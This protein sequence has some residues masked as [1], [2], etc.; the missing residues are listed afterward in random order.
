MDQD[1]A[2]GPTVGST[3]IE[4]RE[5]YDFETIG[6]WTGFWPTAADGARYVDKFVRNLEIDP[7]GLSAED[8]LLIS[9]F[10]AVN[11]D[12]ARWY[13]KR[14]GLERRIHVTF[15]IIS[16][17]LLVAL[18]VLLLK[19]PSWLISD[20]GSLKADDLPVITAQITAALTGFIAIHKA[21]G[22]WLGQRKVIGRFW[23]ARLKLV[24][25]IYNIEVEWM[26]RAAAGVDD[27]ADAARSGLAEACRNDLRAGVVAG[28]QIV[29]EE[30][31]T[32][33]D[34]YSVPD[35]DLSAGLL[36]AGATAGKLVETFRSPKLAAADRQ[37]ART[38]ALR[39][40]HEERVAAEETALALRGAL[41][42][43][44]A[45]LAGTDD[46]DEK[47]YLQANVKA[48]QTKLI[49]A[50]STLIEKRARHAAESRLAA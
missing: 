36:N 50:E 30:T 43:A 12:N 23:R 46:D 49:A 16:I 42:D 18:P 21:L 13:W 17:V 11:H 10:V 39:T 40:A 19:L 47:I 7:A 27:A 22:A 1:P 2:G 37:L 9:R 14:V 6:F 24:D 26:G 35:V 4:R 48:L 38:T 5:S 3:A 25:L 34:Q 20:G 32:Y 41:N 29:R 28:R 33:F 8:R 31:A 15:V 44:R 45:A